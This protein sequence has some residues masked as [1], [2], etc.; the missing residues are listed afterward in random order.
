MQYRWIKQ[1]RTDEAIVNVIAKALKL[2]RALAQ[3]LVARGMGSIDKALTFFHPG[4]EQLYSPYLFED[5]A[6]AVA[7]IR[8]AIEQGENLWIYGDYDVDGVVSTVLLVDY[9]RRQGGRV[10]YRLSERQ[11]ETYGLSESVI[12]QA[13]EA[14][15]SLIITVDLGTTSVESVVYANRMG[16]D[17]IIC[18]HHEPAE[19]LPPA[20]ALLNPLRPRTRYPFPYLAAAGVTFKLLQ[21]LAEEFSNDPTEAYEYLDLVAIATAS[22]MVPLV[23]ENRIFV[24]FGLKQ[25]NAQPRVGIEALLQCTT[26]DGPVSAT[27]VTYAL[28]PPINAAGRLG[29]ASIAVELL[30][31]DNE[32]VAFR[33]AQ[34][35][36]SKN[37]QRRVIDDQV[38]AEAQE[39]AQQYL[40]QGYHSLVLYNAKWHPGVI[41][42]IA[43]RLVEK[44]HVPT[45]VLTDVESQV[46][47]S[48]RS[49]QAFDILRAMKQLR[50]YLIQFGGH[51]YA[52]GLS[53]H[54]HNVD[55]FRQAFERIVHRSLAQY[56]FI[57]EL[58]IDAELDFNDLSPVFLKRLQKFAPFGYQNPNPLFVAH[59]VRIVKMPYRSGGNT[60]RFRAKQGNFVIDVVAQNLEDRLALFRSNQPLSMVFSIEENGRNQI[61]LSAKDFRLTEE[62]FQEA[63]LSKVEN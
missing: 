10:E 55:A 8:T 56:H 47:G 13:K 32:L 49:F 34:E 45:V 58:Q 5:M 57:P 29:D 19:Q 50:R 14:G 28:S 43:S 52:V 21:A 36:Q 30:L 63:K 6:A 61:Y 39:Q 27:T 9:L 17:V 60:Y 41:N 35:L 12:Q 51:R 42:I 59:H 62:Y 33:Y 4:L 7:R 20:L 54:P 25:L 31:T 53:L 23:D 38:F 1:R 44:Y 2:P 15:V 3:V 48:A 40:D 22:D 37:H 46:K 16:I 18:D 11:D 26:V 24:H